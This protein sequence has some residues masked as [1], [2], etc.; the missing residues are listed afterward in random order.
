MSR[1]P[2]TLAEAVRRLVETD[3][4][5]YLFQAAKDGTKYTGA[6]PRGNAISILKHMDGHINEAGDKAKGQGMGI[7]IPMF[8]GSHGG[9]GVL[10]LATKPEEQ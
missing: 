6:M 8:V 3:P 4:L 9:M 10:F 1:D 2:I 5:S 7:C